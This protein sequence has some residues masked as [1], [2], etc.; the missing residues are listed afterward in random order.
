MLRCFSCK[1]AHHA[2]LHQDTS[3]GTSDEE[4]T[5]KVDVQNVVT[6]LTFITIRAELGS[7]ILL[8]LQL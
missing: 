6:T 1:G 2:W 8:Q 5:F 3:C 7:Y 4:T